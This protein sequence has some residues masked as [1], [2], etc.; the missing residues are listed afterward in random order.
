MNKHFKPEM[1]AP[2]GLD[3]NICSQALI[4][5]IRVPDATDRTRINRSSARSIA[6]LFSVKSA[7]RMAINIVTNVLTV[8]ALFPSITGRAS[9]V[10]KKSGNRHLRRK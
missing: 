6:E 5:M 1:V 3:C 4:E 10:A 8:E 9:R 2:C 7:G